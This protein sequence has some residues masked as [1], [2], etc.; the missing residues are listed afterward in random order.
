VA[1]DQGWDLASLPLAEVA[2]AVDRCRLLADDHARRSD[3]LA[4]LADAY[5]QRLLQHG[6][7]A[8]VAML[9]PCCLFRADDARLRV[10][11]DAYRYY[12]P[13]K[14][15]RRRTTCTHSP[16]PRMPG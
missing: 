16:S 9:A 10:L 4:P 2:A 7:S 6:A 12:W 1:A 11:Q 5:E 15:R 13:T 8:F 14:G 3:A